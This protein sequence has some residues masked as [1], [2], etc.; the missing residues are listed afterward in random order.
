MAG[1]NKGTLELSTIPPINLGERLKYLIEYPHGCIEQTTSSVFPQ[2]YLDQLMDLDD[3]TTQAMSA[4]IKAG[5]Q[6]IRQFQTSSGGFGYWP[7]DNIAC[8]WGTSYAGHFLLEAETKGYALPAGILDNW[9]RYQKQVAVDWIPRNEKYYYYND[10]LE[11]AYRLYT[12][13]LANTP[14]LGAMNRLREYRNLSIAAKWR[15]AAAYV[16]ARQDDVA[17]ALVAGI[18]TTVPKYAEMS[19]T[20]G[21]SDRDEA[22]ILETLTLLGQRAKAATAAKDISDVLSN[23]NYWMSTQSTA[24]CLLSMSKFAMKGG[25]SKELNY[26]FNLNGTSG[27]LVSSKG[28]SQVD[29]KMKDNSG[30]IAVDNKGKGVLYA[31]II[32]EGIPE[33]GDQKDYDN[34]LITR[35]DYKRMDGTSLNVEKLE[36][37]TDFYAEISITNTNIRSDYK[38]MALN[39]IFPSGWEI[40]NSRMDETDLEKKSDVPTYQDIRDDRVYSYFD[41]GPN[42]TKTFRIRLNASYLGRFYLP[43]VV[44]EAMYDHTISSCRHGRW[45]EVREAGKIQ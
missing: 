35:I 17:K 32:L 3:K 40:W 9:K 12:L 10:D 39:Q 27:S 37:G 5:L 18:P 33:A 28:V 41:L 34:N 22:M 26:S 14:E 21:S 31:R 23:H 19:Y 13:A 20:Y 36:Q 38:E 30:K 4:N 15:L 44:C 45:V 24:Y 43:S 2:L 16:L 29:L 8:A 7:G 11:Q 1:T 6:R 25:T 42:K